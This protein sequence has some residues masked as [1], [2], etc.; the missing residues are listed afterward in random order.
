MF[1]IRAWTPAT[2]RIL[3]SIK[4]FNTSF[5]WQFLSVHHLCH[6]WHFLGD[7]EII[8]HVSREVLYCNIIYV[9]ACLFWTGAG[10]ARH[11]WWWRCRWNSVSIVSSGCVAVTLQAVLTLWDDIAKTCERVHLHALP[12]VV[13]WLAL[14]L[15]FRTGDF[16]FLGVTCAS[17]LGAAA[18]S[19]GGVGR[20]V[21]L[22]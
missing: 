7:V 4:Y 5:L 14:A 20:T 21:Q 2:F 13:T 8:L 6:V 19:L 15:T 12:A 9:A 16:C 3:L 11:Q 22:W 17:L 18:R 10:W 1:D